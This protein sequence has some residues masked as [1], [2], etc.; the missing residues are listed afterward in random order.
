MPAVPIQADQQ[1]AII[2]EYMRLHYLVINRKVS[3][4]YYYLEKKANELGMS[5]RSAVSI[6]RYARRIKMIDTLP[7][8]R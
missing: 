7:N 6:V 4:I 3:K 5:L 2:L 1:E 8:Y